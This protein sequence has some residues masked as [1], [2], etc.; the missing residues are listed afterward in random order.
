MSAPNDKSSN[1][2]SP[3]FDSMLDDL[4]RIVSEDTPKLPSLVFAEHILRPLIDGRNDVLVENWMR[5]TGS[6]QRQ[7]AVIDDAGEIIGYAPPL[8]TSAAPKFTESGAESLAEIGFTAERRS[9]I[10]PRMGEI[11]LNEKLSKRDVRL[12]SQYNAMR[13]WNDLTRRIGGPEA[14]LPFPLIEPGSASTGGATPATASK[15]G[16]GTLRFSDQDDDF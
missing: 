2:L 11:Y 14:D 3:A 10:S 1:L 15:V 8:I 7:I 13:R 6:T 16:D 12:E 4:T 5:L 9:E